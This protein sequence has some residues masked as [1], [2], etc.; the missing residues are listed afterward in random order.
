[1]AIDVWSCAKT[2]EFVWS[3]HCSLGVTLM[4]RACGALIGRLFF[5]DR[6]RLGARFVRLINREGQRR[7]YRQ[8]CA[9]SAVLAN[10]QSATLGLSY[11]LAH[12]TFVSRPNPTEHWP[13]LGGSNPTLLL[14]RRLLTTSCRSKVSSRPYVF[15]HNNNILCCFF[16]CLFFY[17]NYLFGQ[18]FKILG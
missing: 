5:R 13:R 4:R 9:R 2:I 7:K 3:V 12:R 1:M 14:H 15:S 6:G 8:T 10:H 11:A 16:V 18:V 17:H